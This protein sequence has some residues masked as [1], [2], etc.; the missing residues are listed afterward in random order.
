M[1]NLFLKAMGFLYRKTGLYPKFVQVLMDK[2]FQRRIS[3]YRR[4]YAIKTVNSDVEYTYDC[5][6]D[7][8]RGELSI[9]YGFYRVFKHKRFN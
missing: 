2:E 9:E 7:I 3:L 6:L 8:K 4:L 5:F 1:T